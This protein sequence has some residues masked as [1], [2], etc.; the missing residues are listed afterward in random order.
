MRKS[1]IMKTH[2]EWMY[3]HSLCVL[4]YVFKYEK[5]GDYFRKKVLFFCNS[6]KDTFVKNAH[7]RSAFQP[8]IMKKVL[9]MD[10]KV[11]LRGWKVGDVWEST[12]RREERAFQTKQQ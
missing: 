11:F 9:E 3:S 4:F 8:F 2:T 10:H 1:N 5:I 6:K 7:F 12:K